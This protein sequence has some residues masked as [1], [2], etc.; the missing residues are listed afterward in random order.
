[1]P[2]FTGERVIPDQVEADLFGEHLAR[3]AFAS[4]YAA[5]KRVLDCGCGTGYGTAELAEAAAEV[6]GIDLSAD[7][8]NY[9]CERYARPNVRYATGSCLALPFPDGSFDLAV[10]F[11]VIE[12]LMDFRRFLAEC[13]RVLDPAGLLIASTPNKLYY[14]EARAQSGPNPYH[15]HEFEAAEFREELSN[16]FPHVTMLVQNHAECFSFASASGSGAGVR[17]DGSPGPENEAHFFVALC[18]AR[19]IGLV[20][21]FIYVPTSANILREREHH[22]HKLEDELRVT[23]GWL[24]QTQDDRNRLLDQHQKLQNSYEEQNQW[25]KRLDA[26]LTAANERICEVQAQFAAEQQA[27]L[28]VVRAYDAKVNDLEAENAAKTQWA[29]DTEARLTSEIE[30]IAGELAECVRLLQ[31]AEDTV[32][33]RTQWAQRLESVKQELEAKLAAVRAS[34]WLKLGRKLGL[35]PAVQ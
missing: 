33:E 21:S 22:I 4:R 3:Y 10:A 20:P 9:A 8:I 11:E 14:A 23:Q 1:M 6:M 18:S 34:R 16:V 26:S 17:I 28:D 29:F 5:G 12:H 27:A 30:R 35:G 2:E 13:A 31:T 32:V 25:A 19:E 24:A 7:A 15:E